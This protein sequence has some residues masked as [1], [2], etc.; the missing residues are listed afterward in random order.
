[1]KRWNSRETLPKDG[2]KIRILWSNGKE[3]VGYFDRIEYGALWT[4]EVTKIEHPEI[5]AEGG[6]WSTDYGEGDNSE[7][8][9][10]GWLPL[11]ATTEA[12]RTKGADY[13]D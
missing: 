8:H 11:T 4:E 12:N 2:T 13:D 3:D 6:E 1:M 10:V 7:F 9:P 5:Y